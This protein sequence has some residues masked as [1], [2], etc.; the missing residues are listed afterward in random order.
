MSLLETVLSAQ[1]G[2][3]LQNLAKANGINPDQALQVLGKLVPGLAQNVQKNTAQSEGLDSLF[4]AIQKGGHDRYLNDSEALFGDSGRQEGNGILGHILGSKDA[5]RSMAGQ[6]SADTGIASSI[7]KALLPQA[8]NLVMGALNQQNGR[9]GA[10]EQIMGMLGGGQKQQASGLLGAFL[11]RD[12][13]G[14]ILDDVM[15]MAAKQFL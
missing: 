3:L 7:I 4:N 11:D 5:S 14:S 2:K 13:D 1:G 9:G 8:A 10:L 15:A 12:K 6:V